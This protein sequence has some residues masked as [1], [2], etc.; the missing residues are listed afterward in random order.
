MFQLSLHA[1]TYITQTCIALVF[2]EMTTEVIRAL[3]LSC[4][5]K[6]NKWSIV[7]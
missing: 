1:Y 2:S 3:N 7:C 5:A 6:Y 4:G